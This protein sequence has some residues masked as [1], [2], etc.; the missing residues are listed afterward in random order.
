MKVSNNFECQVKGKI[1]HGKAHKGSTKVIF[2]HTSKYVIGQSNYLVK[3]FPGGL[4]VKDPAL[5]LLRLRF[6]P[7]P[8]NFCMQWVPPLQKK[9]LHGQAC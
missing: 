8:R 5:S 3:E 2:A 6:N 4:V 7:W 1:G 9:K